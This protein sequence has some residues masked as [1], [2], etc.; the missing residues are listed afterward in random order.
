MEPIT[1]TDAASVSPVTAMAESM[2]NPALPSK[3]WESS[4]THVKTREWRLSAQRLYNRHVLRSS[5]ARGTLNIDYAIESIMG[6]SL[7]PF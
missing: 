4:N 5:G 2:T 3:D 1:Q 6:V 7:A